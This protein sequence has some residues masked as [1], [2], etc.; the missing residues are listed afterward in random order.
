MKKLLIFCLTIVLACACTKTIVKTT[1]SQDTKIKEKENIIVQSSISKSNIINFPKRLFLG[2]KYTLITL[3][4]D[5]IISSNDTNIAKIEENNIIN[6]VNIGKCIIFSSVNGVNFQYELE[7]VERKNNNYEITKG[8]SSNVP[9][10]LKSSTWYNELTTDILP[11][12][13]NSNALGNPVGNFPTYRDEE[14]K[15]IPDS[16][17]KV[18]MMSR[19]V[20]GYSMAFLVTGNEQLLVYAHSGVKWLIDN[21]YDK[22]N[23]C[24][25]PDL[26]ASGKPKRNEPKYAQDISYSLIGLAAYFFVTRDKEVE[27]I[28]LETHDT[29]FSKFWDKKNKRLYDAMN[30]QLTEEISQSGDSNNWELVAQLDQINAYLLLVQ[31]VLSEKSRRDEFMNNMITLT[32]TLQNS[33]WKDGIFWG[34]RSNIGTFNTRH[35]D[36]G[37]TLKAYWMIHQLDKRIDGNPYYSF[38]NGNIDYWINLAYYEKRGIW[39]GQM[40]SLTAGDY[41]AVWWI[42]AECDQITATLNIRTGKYTDILDKTSK[43]WR[44]YFIDKKNGGVYSDI[45][46]GSKQNEW[47]SS[48]HEIEHALIMYI[49]GKV[50]EG[51]KTPLY[52]A[53]PV[54]DSSELAVKPYIFNGKEESRKNIGEFLI[55]GNKYKKVIIDFA[56]VY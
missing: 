52:F 25:Y 21:A 55:N 46:K 16:D 18:R 1:A 48:Y 17:R 2:E 20:Y 32:S 9:D 53:F 37:H 35:V 54:D 34:Q 15:E 14:G 41:E 19:Q 27:K 22:E 30:A 33:F 38:I 23:G 26:N 28:I 36:F 7:V 43:N 8:S 29:L 56:D 49:H 24:W 12:W 50:L 31:P 44:K 40:N 4:N 47:K 39:H 10:S 51:D 6:A 5:S 11:Y 45:Y 3:A 13:T 42:Y